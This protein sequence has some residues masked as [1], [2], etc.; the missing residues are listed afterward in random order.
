MS[1]FFF[2]SCKAKA[3]YPEAVARLVAYVKARFGIEPAGLPPL[4]PQGPGSGRHGAGCLQQLRRHSG[5]ELGSRRIGFVWNAVD[6]HPSFPFPSCGGRPSR[7]RTAVERRSVQDA[8]RS[9]LAKMNFRVCELSGHHERMRFCGVNLLQKCNPSNAW[10][11]PRRYAERGPACSRPCRRMSRKPASAG[12]AARSGPNA[13]PA[14]ANFARTPSIQAGRGRPSA[15]PS[16]SRRHVGGTLGLAVVRCCVPRYKLR[17]FTDRMP[18]GGL[19]EEWQALPDCAGFQPGDTVYSLCHK[20][21]VI[22][23]EQKPGVRVRSL[24]ELLLEEGVFRFPDFGGM[25]MAV[26]DCWRACDR[27][28]EQDAVRELLRRMN[29]A[30][31]DLAQDREAAEFCD[32]S[33]L[34]PAP[35]RNLK[36]APKRYVENAHGKFLPHTEEEQEAA[37]RAYAAA[38]PQL[39][40]AVYC[41]YCEKGLKLAGVDVRHLA[42]LLFAGDAGQKA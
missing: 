27:I 2:P 34:R 5:R 40:V 1:T 29:V 38:L 9:I 25:K 20:C 7:C 4:R 39:P 24:W 35:P 8:V 37:M 13:L 22:I 33:L 26:Q 19:R 30:P 10:L 16:L 42:A 36:L 12:T 6:A 14:M 28:E 18:E 3:D 17:S 31:V 11:A 32:M 21:S 41:H 15:E 23:E